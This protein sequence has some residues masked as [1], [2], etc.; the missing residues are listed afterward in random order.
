MPVLDEGVLHGGLVVGLLEARHA[1][2]SGPEDCI[3]DALTIAVGACLVELGHQAV[4][5]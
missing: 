4:C 1:C 5:Q 3:L 2:G